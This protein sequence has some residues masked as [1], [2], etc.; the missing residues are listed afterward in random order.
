MA[1]MLDYLDW[2]G[3]LT[4]QQSKFNEVDNLLIAQMCYAPFEGIVKEGMEGM[5][6]VKEVADLYFEKYTLRK[7][8]SME[9][10]QIRATGVLAKMA[11][12]KRFKDCYLGFYVQQT[13]EKQQFSAITMD[14]GE[15]CLYIAFRGTDN[16]LVGWKEDLT[17]CYASNIQSQKDAV[18]YLENIKGL[19]PK[20]KIYVG[21]HSKGG[22]LSVYAAVKCKKAYQKDILLVFNNDGPGFRKDIVE[23]KEYMEML[24]KIRTIVPESSIVGMLLEHR[25]AY[26][27]VRSTQSGGMQH[28]ATSWEV[29]GRHFIYLETVSDGSKKIDSTISAWIE[30]LTVEEKKYVVD[31][32]FNVLMAA[33]FSTVTSIQ[34]EPLKNALALVKEMKN[35][36]PQT[37]K[38]ISTAVSMLVKEGNKTVRKAIPFP[39][40]DEEK[41]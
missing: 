13:T 39:Y 34:K 23:S 16:T 11:Q 12:S 22:N 26:T 6:T 17:M 25:E 3:D 37:K 15:N 8:K 28:D 33:G 7:Q 40:E 31:A 27:I 35:L 19:Y 1:N 9:S 24:P 14:L 30:D 4:F 36:T 41:G 5:L 2:R 10:Q 21:G 29:L 32:I 20:K 38:Y 18:E